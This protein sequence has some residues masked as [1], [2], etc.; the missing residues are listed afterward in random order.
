MK[1]KE[2]KKV[3]ENWYIAAKEFNFKIITPFKFNFKNKE[4]TIFALL[5]NFGSEKGMIIDLI[6]PPEFSTDI[7]IVEWANEN[8]YFYSFINIE[9]YLNYDKEVFNETLNDWG[10]NKIK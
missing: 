5:P 7:E 9:S 6:Y 10:Y 4:K 2:Y 8:S 3:E 1:H